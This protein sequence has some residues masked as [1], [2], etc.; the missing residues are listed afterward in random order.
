LVPEPGDLATK[1]FLRRFFSQI[2]GGESGRRE[3]VVGF[4]R[5]IPPSSPF[6]R[7]WGVCRRRH[8]RRRRLLDGVDG[9]GLAAAAQF[10]HRLS[11]VTRLPGIISPGG[12]TLVLLSIRVSWRRALAAVDGGGRSFPPVARRDAKVQSF[13]GNGAG[14]RSHEDGSRGHE[15]API[16]YRRQ[17]GY[18]TNP[19]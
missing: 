10:G 18:S 19:R 16:R 11:K 2:C 13:R 12:K 1:N 7:R 8:W 14:D 5:K 9:G 4:S 6:S 3:T 15:H 17:D